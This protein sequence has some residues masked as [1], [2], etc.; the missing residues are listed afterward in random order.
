MRQ[1]EYL[2][3]LKEN[4]EGKVSAEELKDILADYEGFFY[5][6]REEGKTDDE[7]SDELGSPA[8]LAK[9]LLEEINRRGNGQSGD[10][11]RVQGHSR[12]NNHIA[13]PGRR[14]CAFLIDAAIAVLPVLVISLMILRVIIVPYMMFLAYPSP[15][16]GAS[17]FIGYAAFSTFT[18]E[19][20]NGV[21]E[22]YTYRLDGGSSEG[23][24]EKREVVSLDK[25]RETGRSGSLIY[26]FAMVALAFYLFY[27]LVST[28]LFRGQT[29]GKKLMRIRIR[30]SNSG[31]VRPIDIF[32]REF[33]G[34]TIINSIPLVPIVS[35]F[36]I[37][38]TQEHKALHDMLV[39]TVVAEA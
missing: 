19:K 6:G 1:L 34:K 14:F 15:G 18:V 5:S 9:S 2:R 7:I 27:S 22:T 36:T 29:I 35:L 24:Y 38:F 30:S 23:T 39:D 4:L 26:I 20:S 8:F 33:L 3:E 11:E 31:A 37:L 16:S 28:L 21:E 12:S 10:K 32:I 13:K 17:L 25:G